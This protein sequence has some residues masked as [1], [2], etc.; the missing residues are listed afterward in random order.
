MS[1]DYLSELEEEISL[2]SRKGEVILQ[3]DF[4]ARTGTLNECIL[5]D[6]FNSTTLPDDYEVD[7]YLNRLSEDCDNVD[8]RGRALIDVCS[9]HS[10]RI[11]NGRTV[12]DLW[13]KKTCFK[14]NGS[15]L[16]DYVICHK[17]NF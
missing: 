7:N 17:D 5:I 8:T 2:F 9:E 4:N 12:G 16:V 14:Y 10:L 11:A 6:D 1:D 13:G 15:S 3:G